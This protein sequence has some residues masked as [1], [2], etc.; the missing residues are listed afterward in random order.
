[1]K[2]LLD[3]LDKLHTTELGIERIKR[4][5]SLETDNVI[6]WCKNKISSENAA[7]VRKGKNWYITVDGCMITV[8]AYSYTIITAHKVNKSVKTL[9]KNSKSRKKAW[10]I[11][12]ERLILREMAMSDYE[13]LYAVLADS[14]IMQHYPYTFD[15]ERVRGWI[16]KNIERYQI[17]GFGLWAVVLKETGEMIGDC[18]LTMQMIGG[19]IKPEIGYHIRCDCQRK[20]YGSEAARAAR[21]WTFRNTPFRVVYSYMKYTN[22]GSYSTA[23]SNGMH[24]VDEF[25]DDVNTITKVYAITKNEWEELIAKN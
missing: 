2:E 20:G 6:G 23:I 13:A 18:G 7:I 5:L 12:T 16:D 3:N 1:M 24:Q 19:Q 8:N 17:F 21:D 14:D 22:I 10:I 11:E 15:E 4:N 25:E 9:L